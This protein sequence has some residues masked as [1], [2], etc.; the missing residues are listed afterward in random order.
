GLAGPARPAARSGPPARA[1]APPRLPRP[2]GDALSFLSPAAFVG[3]AEVQAVQEY[4]SAEQLRALWSFP[5]DLRS[6][7]ADQAAGLQRELQ[8][9]SFLPVAN[10]VGSTLGIPADKVA[11]FSVS[12]SNGLT[13]ILPSFVAAD[14]AVQRALS[15]LL[16][17]L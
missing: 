10:S 13:V 16:V 7:T 8:A 1:A 11:P 4:L 6:V 2:G 12:L 17:S 3:P 5:L 14:D 15:L 9:L